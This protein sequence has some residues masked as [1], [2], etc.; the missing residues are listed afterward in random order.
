MA[1]NSAEVQNYDDHKATYEGFIS[2]CIATTLGTF[3]ILVTLVICGLANTHYI[4]NLIVGFGGMILGFIFVG[5][6]AKAGSNYLT[7]LILLIAFGI[8]AVF[9]IT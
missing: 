8:L 5:V 3:F 9:M 4:T 2:G 6:E 1:E 7:S